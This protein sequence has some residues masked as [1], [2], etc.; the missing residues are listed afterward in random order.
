M[1]RHL[2]TSEKRTLRRIT[3]SL[4]HLRGLREIVD[5]V[6][7][8]FDRRCRSATALERLANLRRRVRRFRRVGRTLQKLFSPNLEKAL[9]SLDDSMLPS[10]S[11]AVE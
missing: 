5:E 4:P 11:N 10:T 9:T 8:L 7:R 2:T 1:K 3:T 6:Y